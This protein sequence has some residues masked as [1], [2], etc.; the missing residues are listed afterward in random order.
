[1][2]SKNDIGIFSIARLSSKRLKKKMIRK[3]SNTTLTD[4]ILSKLSKLGKNAF[5]AG[6]ENIFRKKSIKYN[7]R[8]VQRSK[9]SAISNNSYAQIFSFLKNENYK[10]LLLINPCMPNLRVSTIKKFIQKVQKLNGPAFAVFVEKN[11]FLSKKNV[12]LNFKKL[13][14]S[15]TLDTKKVK[16]IKSFAH[17]FYFFERKYFLK[18]GHYWDW[19]KLNYV[20]IKKT[21]EFLDVDNLK[22]FQEAELVWKISN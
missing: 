5:F 13:K 7:V 20:D 6:Y 10:Y 1:M 9:L 19:S 8:F 11:Y 22:D 16:S 17:I 12:P 2:I 3:F 14:K 4:I 21:N 15:E 18:S